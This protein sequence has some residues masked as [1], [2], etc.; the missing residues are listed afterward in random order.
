M[1]RKASG[2]WSSDSEDAM[3]VAAECFCSRGHRLWRWS[4]SAPESS[5][6]MHSKGLE[7]S[8]PLWGPRSTYPK[9]PETKDDDDEVDDVS[10]EHERID[11]CGCSVLGVQD[12]MEET[13]QGLI[14]ALSSVDGQSQR[15][16]IQRGT[17]FLPRCPPF[18]ASLLTVTGRSSAAGARLPSFFPEPSIFLERDVGSFSLQLLFLPP[19]LPQPL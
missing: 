4:R 12:V 2:T 15:E 7:A 5:E 19:P 8:H 18:P 9:G 16:G 11:I 13:P 10:Q 3:S 6:P 1:K 14:D 17:T